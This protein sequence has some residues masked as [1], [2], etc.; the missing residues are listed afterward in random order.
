MFSFNFIEIILTNLKAA[1]CVRLSSKA[2]A[3]SFSITFVKKSIISFTPVPSQ[4][5][6]SNHLMNP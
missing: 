2:V 6:T 4:A 1:C 3:L 5:D